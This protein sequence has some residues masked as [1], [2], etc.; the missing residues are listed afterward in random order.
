MADPLNAGEHKI[1]GS[2][3]PVSFMFEIR[4]GTAEVLQR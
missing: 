1:E 4:Y 2:D 3:D